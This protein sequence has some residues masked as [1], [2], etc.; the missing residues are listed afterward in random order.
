VQFIV[1]VFKPVTVAAQIMYF[2]AHR[3]P[4]QLDKAAAR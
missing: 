3:A 1:N 4:R 2:A